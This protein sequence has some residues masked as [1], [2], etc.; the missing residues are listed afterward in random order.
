MLKSSEKNNNR[1]R[2]RERIRSD[3]NTYCD[4]LEIRKEKRLDKS[5]EIKSEE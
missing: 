5:K 4:L 1:P 2:E 3:T